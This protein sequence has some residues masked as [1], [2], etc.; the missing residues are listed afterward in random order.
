MS[1][2]TLLQDALNLLNE[3]KGW[4]KQTFA[5]NAKGFTVPP[6]DLDASKWCALGALYAATKDWDDFRRA[7]VYLIKI[8][9]KPLFD[10]ALIEFNDSQEDFFQIKK[11]FEDAIALAE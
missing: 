6:H 4:T 7:K 5:T 2:K 9:K 11:L 10:A 1:A 3:G 8:M